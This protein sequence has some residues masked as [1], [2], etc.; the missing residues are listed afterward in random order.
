MIKHSDENKNYA[1][2]YVIVHCTLHCLKSQ[3]YNDIKK[4]IVLGWKKRGVSIF[5]FIFS[6][7]ELWRPVCLIITLSLHHWG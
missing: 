1:K 6:D 5:L 2:T 4:T 3:C 7:I